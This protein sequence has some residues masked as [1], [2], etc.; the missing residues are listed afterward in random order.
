M[1]LAVIVSNR[2]QAQNRVKSLPV[3]V[4]IDRELLDWVEMLIERRMFANRSHAVN[5]AINFLK[6]TLEHNPKAFY[7]ERIGPLNQPVHQQQP[8]TNQN[9]PR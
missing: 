1:L 3:T 9:S 5:Q 4:T 8:D 6:W 2:K 7:G